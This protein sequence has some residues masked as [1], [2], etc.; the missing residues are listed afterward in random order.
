MTSI[1]SVRLG[2]RIGDV[3]TGPTP[4]INGE[5]E[6]AHFRSVRSDTR[7]GDVWTCPT[8][9]INEDAESAPTFNLISGS[10]TNSIFYS[11]RYALT[12]VFMVSM[13]YLLQ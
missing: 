12:T 11:C 9:A 5:A 3:W 13:I 6:S 2:K 4:A 8:P 10:S 1:R 7:R